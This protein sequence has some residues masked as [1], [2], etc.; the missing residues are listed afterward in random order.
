MPRSKHRAKKPERRPARQTPEVSSDEVALFRKAVADAEPLEHARPEPERPK[1]PARARFSRADEEQVL[2]ESLAADLAASEV[3][4][5]EFLSFWRPAVGRRTF[6]KL[7]RGRFS[8]QGEC[9]LHGMTVPEAR[10]H[11]R[12]FITTATDG[13]LSCVRVVHGKGRGSGQ[14]GPIIKRK[15]DVWLR[16]WDEVL[17]FVSAKPVDGGTGAL[18]VLLKHR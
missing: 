1:I 8:I 3:G 7:S 12:S 6:R 5:G 18:Y 16:R 14:N 4:S 15:V 17:A 2:D 9:D 13:G 10:D 11:L